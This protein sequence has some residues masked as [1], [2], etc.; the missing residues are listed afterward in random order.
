MGGADDGRKEEEMEELSCRGGKGMKIVYARMEEWWSAG[1]EGVGEWCCGRKKG[2][3]D[4][5]IKL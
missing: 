3:R 1:R 4:E 5:G 2:G